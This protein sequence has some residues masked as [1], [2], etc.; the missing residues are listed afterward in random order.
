MP[1]SLATR[2]VPCQ[3][4]RLCC[5][6]DAVR[7]EEE[8]L[9]RGYDTEPHPYV[10]GALMIAHKPN[11]DCVYLGEEGC[12]IHGRAPALCRAADCRSLAL[13]YGLQAA[14]ALHMTGRLNFAVW[15]RGNQLLADMKAEMARGQQKRKQSTRHRRRR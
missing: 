3:G 7:L 12:T 5:Q 10:P 14:Q 9:S 11:G 15:D 2:F 4:C 1:E 8:D 13:R 6:G